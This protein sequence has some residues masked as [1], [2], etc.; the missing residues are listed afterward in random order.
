MINSYSYTKYILGK[1]HPLFETPELTG[2]ERVRFADDG[3]DIDTGRETTHEF[4]VH[5][6]QTVHQ[7]QITKSR[8]A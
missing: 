4:Y 7:Q 1:P 8:K 5:F 2:C 6:T 3:D